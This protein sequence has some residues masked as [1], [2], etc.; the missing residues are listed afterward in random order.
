MWG[1]REDELSLACLRLATWPAPRRTAWI[2]AGAERRCRSFALPRSA[3]TTR[4]GRPAST[5]RWLS[6]ELTP[7]SRHARWPPGHSIPR[8]PLRLPAGRWPR[9]GGTVRMPFGPRS[10]RTRATGPRARPA[11]LSHGATA[12]SIRVDATTTAVGARLARRPSGIRPAARPARCTGWE[13]FPPAGHGLT[14][15]V[16]PRSTAMPHLTPTLPSR[17]RRRA[18]A[19]LGGLI[20]RAKGDVAG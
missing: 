8:W 16:L 14:A 17:Y 10:F 3:R 1:I 6:S 4:T 2:P 20:T 5:V 19:A 11:F 15:P 18:L 13:K 9:H 7:R 12:D